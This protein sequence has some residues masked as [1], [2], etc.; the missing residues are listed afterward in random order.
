LKK[1]PKKPAIKAKRPK[2][3]VTKPA[4]L[5]PAETQPVV[6]RLAEKAE[7]KAAKVKESSE[8]QIE[9]KML[10]RRARTGDQRAY[11]ELV[12]RHKRGIE[13]LIRPI[14]RN[15]SSDEVEDLVQEALTKA[16]THLDSYSEEYAFSTW[17]YRIA[18]NHAID[19]LRR[20]RL[21]M[22]S[23][24]NAPGGGDSK[25]GDDDGKDLELVDTSW[26]P[27]D[28]LLTAERTKLIE[29]AIEQLPE[30]YK[31]IIKLRH[32]DDL[33]YDEIAKQLNLPMGTVKVHLHRARAALGKLLEGKI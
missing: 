20:R 22:F 31:R 10:V 23:I 15:A 1:A 17:L 11:G 8:R 9:D 30:N 19:H 28:V 27:D 13:R 4:A 25:S 33:E 29:E 2:A 14:V 6:S 5:P 24:S 32:N 12:K 26:V 7:Q 18:T 21:S 3:V 16:L